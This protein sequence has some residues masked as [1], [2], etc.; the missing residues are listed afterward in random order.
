M[1]GRKRRAILKKTIARMI[2][3]FFILIHENNI[4]G[5]I[6]SYIHGKDIRMPT[7][8]VGETPYNKIRL[9]PMNHDVPNSSPIFIIT[10]LK[11]MNCYTKFQVAH[12][13]LHSAHAKIK[14][15]LE[16]MGHEELTMRAREVGRKLNING[17]KVISSKRLTN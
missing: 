7:F 16:T 11:T 3:F 2:F 1:Q 5:R 13:W 12:S 14:C 10:V 4:E 8:Q 9:C 17:K 6:S 15:L